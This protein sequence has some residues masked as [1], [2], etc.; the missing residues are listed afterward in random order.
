ML[1]AEHMAENQGA[2]RDHQWLGEIAAGDRLVHRIVKKPH[3][4]LLLHER[5]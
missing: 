1:A 3:D 4:I 5:P 2:G